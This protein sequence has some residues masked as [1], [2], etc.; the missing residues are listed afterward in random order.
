MDLTKAIEAH[1]QWKTKFRAAIQK[2]ETMDA[3]TIGKDDCCELGKWLHGNE[4]QKHRA[5]ASYKD[6]VTMHASFHK[7]AGQIATAINAKKFA[8]AEKM[9]AIGT[10]FASLSAAVGVALTRLKL[11]AKLQ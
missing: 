3:A 8:D 5:L 2:Q 4:T 1:V 6:A 10:D 9:I 7:T 11:D